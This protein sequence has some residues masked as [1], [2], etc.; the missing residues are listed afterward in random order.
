MAISTD[1]IKRVKAMG[2]L[3]N[4]GTENFSVRVIT[5][6]G[7]I[8]AEQNRVISEVA[9]KY[10]NGKVTFT[11]RLTVELPGIHFSN[12]EAV[13]EHLATVGLVT[14]GTGA[15]VRPIVACKGTVCNYGL[16][17]TQALGAEIHER[18]FNGYNN[19]KLPHKFK[20]AVGGCPNNCVKPDLNDL[21]IIGQ[22]VSN[23]DK[24]LCRGC[25]KCRIEDVCPMKAAK[26]VNG[27][28]QIN[29][30]LCNNCGLCVG[31]CYFNAIE[32]GVKGFKIYIGGRWGKKTAHGIPLRKIFTTKEEAFDVIEKAILLFK[33]QG[34]TRERFAD[35]IERLGFENVEAQLL[36]NELLER[37]QEIL[38]A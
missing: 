5:I 34:K 33:E 8:S 10:G 17:D 20:I 11:S 36:Q 1:E 32:T 28:L 30:D 18:F 37:K 31:K 6:M 27:I 7:A 25:K 19:I 22:Y 12:I 23:F 3:H 9:E 15:K 2:F 14:G 38:N 4:R 35:T 13:R 21:G 16:Q 29:K 24:N 26:V